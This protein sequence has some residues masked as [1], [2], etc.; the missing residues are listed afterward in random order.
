M[1][2]E[3]QRDSSPLVFRKEYVCRLRPL[4]G[5]PLRETCRVLQS[6]P[7]RRPC[8]QS[9]LPGCQKN[10]LSP[11]RR[12]LFLPVLWKHRPLHQAGLR[13]KAT[14][15]LRMTTS[16]ISYADHTYAELSAHRSPDSLSNLQTANSMRSRCL[17]RTNGGQISNHAAQITK[18]RSDAFSGRH[19]RGAE[20]HILLHHHPSRIIVFLKYAEEF[21]KIDRALP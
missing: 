4:V 14:D 2:H 11:I 18:A 6:Q 13:N 19:R 9:V 7:R 3:R 16:H 17:K 10:A 20:F 12:R 21:R 1:R 15:V 8:T 5:S